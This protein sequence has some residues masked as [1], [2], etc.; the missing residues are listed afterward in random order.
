MNKMPPSLIKAEIKKVVKELRNELQERAYT[1][2]TNKTVT[3]ESEVMIS[4]DAPVFYTESDVKSVNEGHFRVNLGNGFGLD[5]VPMN[6]CV[7]AFASFAGKLLDLKESKGWPGSM[8]NP[9]V[10]QA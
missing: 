4:S 6:S 10:G 8:F 9:V 5:I 2:V 3:E 1:T 7:W